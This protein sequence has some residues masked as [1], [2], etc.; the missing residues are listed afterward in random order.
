M[1][2]SGLRR[3]FLSGRR[4]RVPHDHQPHLPRPFAQLRVNF[5]EGDF[6]LRGKPHLF[7]ECLLRLRVGR[8]H[9]GVPAA[10]GALCETAVF[11]H[12]RTP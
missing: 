5:R 10:A 3:T 12:Y 2:I 8:V 9:A 6:G 7:I 1:R 4:I 11:R